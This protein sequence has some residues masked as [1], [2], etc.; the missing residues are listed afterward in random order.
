MHAKLFAQENFWKSKIEQLEHH[1]QKDVERLTMELKLTQ[2]IADS[3]KAEYES[4]VNDLERQA[5]NQS[6]ILTEQSKQLHSLSNEIN[7]SQLNEKS[8]D[9]ENNLPEIYNQ[10]AI[11]KQFNETE[12]KS[13]ENDFKRESR[14]SMKT[15]KIIVG[16]INSIGSDPSNKEVLLAAENKLPESMHN[17]KSRTQ[18]I[19]CENKRNVE[20]KS[21]ETN[22][23]KRNDTSESKDL[24]FET[25]NN[26]KIKQK[27]QDLAIELIKK[28]EFNESNLRKL[29][30]SSI[31]NISH[32][33][34]SRA[35]NKKLETL[36]DN[37][38]SETSTELS[39]SDSHI[40]SEIESITTIQNNYPLHKYITHTSISSKSKKITE[41]DSLYKE[42]Q[43]N[44]KDIFEQ[45]LRDLGI[46]PEWQG[47]PKATFKQKMDIL[48]HHQK[49]A[50]KVRKM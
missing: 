27:G 24:I 8:H 2:K 19:M 22:E 44:L 14:L 45:K 12:K 35:K 41:H 26:Y 1:H 37:F 42:Q 13:N 49:I 9:S 23:T 50:I 17:L 29:K 18:T 36:L 20:Q 31:K 5:A 38:S 46:D 39:V 3:M 7:F 10:S 21:T 33:L 48:K 28:A 16:N 11:L 43:I 30:G 40:P 15:Q 47:I 25:E 32:D 6:N 4:K 34:L